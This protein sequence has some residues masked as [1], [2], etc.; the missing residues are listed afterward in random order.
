MTAVHVNYR[1]CTTID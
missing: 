1:H